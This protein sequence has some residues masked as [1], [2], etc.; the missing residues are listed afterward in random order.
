MHISSRGVH[1]CHYA[2]T[3][4]VPMEADHIALKL[5]NDS[6]V[7]FFIHLFSFK[8]MAVTGS[9]KDGALWCVIFRRI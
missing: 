3:A 1:R 5:T 7:S 6:T 8:Y 4:G 9:G 2:G